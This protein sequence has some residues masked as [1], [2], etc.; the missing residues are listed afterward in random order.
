M[1]VLGYHVAQSWQVCAW[2]QMVTIPSALAVVGASAL[3]STSA[4]AATAFLSINR[5][6]MVFLSA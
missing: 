3:A 2:G 6:F 5:A 1:N 4:A